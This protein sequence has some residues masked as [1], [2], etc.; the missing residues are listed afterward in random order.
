MSRTQD[1]IVTSTT[2]LR[3]EGVRAFLDRLVRWLR[4]ERRY[5]HPNVAPT[6]INNPQPSAAPLKAEPTPEILPSPEAIL[7]TGS[8]EV[9]SFKAVGEEFLAYFKEWCELKPNERVLD[10]GSGA[11]RAALPLTK[12][13]D[14]RGSYDG[15]EIMRGNVEWCQ[16]NITPYYPNFRFHWADLHNTQ[17]N[18]QGAHPP[19]KYRFPF[20]DGYFDLVFLMSVFTH[21]LPP[22]MENYLSEISRVMKRGSYCLITYFIL[23]PETEALIDNPAIKSLFCI[24]HRY[25]DQHYGVEHENRPEVVTAHYETR[26]RELYSKSHLQI[27]EPIRYGRWPGRAQYVSGQDIVVARKV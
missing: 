16:M 18:P 7:S 17:Y 1:L 9:A 15:I 11:G 21:M 6:I 14:G 4:G 20:E 2:L 5:Y 8:L 3:E 27:V 19:E 12:Y 24:P 26:L 22:G 10:V 23:N 13:L 25:P